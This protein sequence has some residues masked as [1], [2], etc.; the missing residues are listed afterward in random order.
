MKIIKLEGIIGKEI[1][2]KVVVDEIKAS[3]GDI[4]INLSSA[5]GVL[6]DGI[7]IFNAIRNYDKG[8]IVIVGGSLVASIA[9][10]F[11]M[12]ADEFVVYDNSTFMIH[13]AHTVS[14]GDYVAFTKT[15]EIL[16]GVTA[17]MRDAYV[18]KSG[19]TLEAIKTMLDKETYIFGA[20]I[21]SQGFADRVLVSG[22]EFSAITAVDDAKEKIINCANNCESRFESESEKISA[23]LAADEKQLELNKEAQKILREVTQ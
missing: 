13:N 19:K 2:A 5:G 14:Q 21:V 17:L 4:T 9:S 3:V 22:A 20:D 11:A 18:A 8:R 10:Y 23:L 15:V 12:A 1:I 6:F 7:E 16:E